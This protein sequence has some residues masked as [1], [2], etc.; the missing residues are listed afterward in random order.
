MCS[1][2]LSVKCVHL[3]MGMMTFQ[4]T[5][6]CV[7]MRYSVLLGPATSQFLRRRVWRMRKR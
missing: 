4:P 3:R 6:L 7:C 1:M 5:S 2:Y